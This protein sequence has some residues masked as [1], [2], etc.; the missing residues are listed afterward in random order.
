MH[1]A[2]TQAEEKVFWVPLWPVSAP[3]GFVLDHTFSC[4]LRRMEGIARDVSLTKCAEVEPAP[5]PA[6]A[7]PGTVPE[8]PQHKAEA[9]QNQWRCCWICGNPMLTSFSGLDEAVRCRRHQ[10]P[11]R[12]KDLE[13]ERKMI[14]RCRHAEALLMSKYVNHALEPNQPPAP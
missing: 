6:S 5:P 14:E 3:Q 8:K 2:T 11:L 12:G 1:E 9:P 4:V 13:R 10:K 7:E